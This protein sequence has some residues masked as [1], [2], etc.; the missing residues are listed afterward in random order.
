MSLGGNT[1]RHYNMHGEIY[2]YMYM[3][4]EMDACAVNVWYVHLA[5]CFPYH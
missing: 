2:V 1:C 3:C 4:S 5:V